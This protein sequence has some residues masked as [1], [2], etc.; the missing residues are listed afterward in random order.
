MS[1]LSIRELKEQL[2]ARQI[3]C[4][5]CT[6]KAELVA[7]LEAA[8][9]GAEASSAT[10]SVAPENSDDAEV[11]PVDTETALAQISNLLDTL[12]SSI[13][14]LDKKWSQ[15]RC[16]KVQGQ[17]R[18]V[19]SLLDHTSAQAASLPGWQARLDE[20]NTLA[21]DFKRIRDLPRNMNG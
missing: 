18:T 2:K 6:E 19:K 14:L 5:G 11:N 10:P 8:T 20:F 4:S 15:T 12:P 7:L 9:G 17:L 3:D 16:D 1:A 21:R 13:T